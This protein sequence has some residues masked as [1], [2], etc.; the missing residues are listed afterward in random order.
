[1]GTGIF[2]SGA[3]TLNIAT[4]GSNRLSVDP[5]GNVG[6]GT[7]TPAQSLEVEGISSLGPAGSVYGYSVN[8]S[9]P[10]PYPTIG[11]NTYGSSYVAGATGYGGILQFQNGDGKLVYYSASA[12]SAGTPHATNVP[13]FTIAANGRVGIG[14]TSL[15]NEQLHVEAVDSTAI[16]AN[17][18]NT[19]LGMNTG[20]AAFS[21]SGHGVYGSSISNV[22]VLGNSSSSFGI[23]GESTSSYG[24]Y[25]TSV[26]N[27]AGYFQGDVYVTGTLTQHSTPEGGSLE[28]HLWT[29]RSHAVS[30]GE[31]DLEAETRTGSAAR[32]HRAGG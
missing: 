19:G 29:A 7:N 8:G 25:G 32:T 4:A 12:A 2:S 24:V 17:T 5:S 15:Q 26:S 18:A 22:G 16:Y 10:G 23:A 21:D 9:S 14:T 31:L 28:P 11:F 27:Y 1:V 3:G 13:R 20:V 30:S 6:I